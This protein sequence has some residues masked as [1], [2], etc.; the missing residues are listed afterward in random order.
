MLALIWFALFAQVGRTR[1]RLG[2][3]LGDNGNPE[4]YTAVRRYGNFVECVP[5]ALLLLYIVEDNGAAAKWVHALGAILVVAR[6]IHPFGINV[7]KM[8]APA[9]IIGAG[10]TVFVIVACAVTLL[11]QFFVA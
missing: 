7:D 10:G 6:A 5:L 1:S 2:I 11:Y 9:R 8:N 4:M 3:G